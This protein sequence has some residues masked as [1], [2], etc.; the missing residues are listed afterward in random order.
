M[1]PPQ[2]TAVTLGVRDVERSRRFYVD[3]LGFRSVL[4]LPGEIS[5]VQGAPGQ[6]L[7]LWN[8][9]SMPSE[10]GDVGHGVQAPPISLG[11]NVTS[12]ERVSELYA[13]ALAAGAT[14][15]SEPQER[16][17]GGVSAC[18]ADLDGFRWDFVFNPGFR[19]DPDGTVH[20]GEA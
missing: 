11:H 12:A 16:E 1:Q 18:V 13:A 4:D 6:L 7:A 5:F 3:G 10:Y 17:W 14:T 15:V 2:I 19:V 9:V 20:L 8:V